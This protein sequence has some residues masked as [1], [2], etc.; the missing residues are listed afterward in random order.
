MMVQTIQFDNFQIWEGR[1]PPEEEP[2]DQQLTKVLPIWPELRT[3]LRKATVLE[4]TLVFEKAFVG[5]ACGTVHVK[6]TGQ[7]VCEGFDV[8]INIRPTWGGLLLKNGLPSFNSLDLLE[9]D[10]DAGAHMATSR[11]LIGQ[12]S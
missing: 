2:F 7:T 6:N 5:G 11:A 12:Q 4:T 9:S 8:E 3:D 1:C 10:V